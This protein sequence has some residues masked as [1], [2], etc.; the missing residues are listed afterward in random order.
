MTT[1]A[2]DRNNPFINAVSRAFFWNHGVFLADTLFLL[3]STCVLA[4]FLEPDGYGIYTAT[5]AFA[6][7]AEVLLAFGYGGALS[8]YLPRLKDEW[9]KARYLVRQMFQRRLTYVVIAGGV[10]TL[11]GPA[12]AQSGLSTFQKIQPLLPLAVGC[13]CLSLLN[14]FLIRVL[15][16][17]FRVHDIAAIQIARSAVALLAFYF[18]LQWGYGIEAVLWITL[19]TYMVTFIFYVFRCRDL[20]FGQRERFPS[21]GVYRFGL[22][23]WAPTLI[24]FVLGK[25]I[26]II[27]LT[28]YGVPAREI[29]LYQV[30][31]ALLAYGT[32]ALTKGLTG[33]LQTAFATAYHGGGVESLKRW[34]EI[35]M[36]FLMVAGVPVILLLVLLAEPIL[37]TVLPNYVEAAPFIH[38]YGVLCLAALLLGGSA[39]VTAF[40]AMEDEKVIVWTRLTGGVLNLFLDVLLIYYFGTLG[41]LVATG[42]SALVV[43]LLEF[44]LLKTKIGVVFPWAFDLKLCLCLLPSGLVSM[45]IAG[46]GLLRLLCS[47]AIFLL[48]CLLTAYFVKP[49]GEE[50]VSYVRK[51]SHRWA[52]WLSLFSPHRDQPV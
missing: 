27:L 45:S 40:Y 31:F 36:K 52:G 43:V 30:T 29:A 37:A 12:L 11:V 15:V 13:A 4:R 21:K 2:E 28:F 48:G 25:N 17:L 23:V 3:L 47:S 18:L 42:V 50:E 26:D 32:A 46:S 35:S 8:V 5:M 14:G 20:L 38:I 49:I 51:L 33:V 24:G 34:W 6:S 7:L 19:L 10:V 9:P 22:N 41:V 39:H 16:T 1:S 44:K